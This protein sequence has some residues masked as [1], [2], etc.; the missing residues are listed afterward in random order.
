MSE[1]EYLDG[2]KK[3]IARKF[4]KNGKVSREIMMVNNVPNG[5][6]HFLCKKLK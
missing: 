2:A 3:F 4:F 5:Y 6:R 1:E